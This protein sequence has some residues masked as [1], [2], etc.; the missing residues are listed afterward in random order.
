M[1]NAVILVLSILIGVAHGMWREQKNI[2]N[3]L[4]E[5]LDAVKPCPQVADEYCL[6]WWFDNANAQT[7]TSYR[8]R[9]CGRK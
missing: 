2:A 8:Q 9:L 1:K 4:Q 3:E 5:K 7:K 6:A